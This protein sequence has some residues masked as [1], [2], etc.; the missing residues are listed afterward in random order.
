MALNNMES[1]YVII[2]AHKIKQC[3]VH[4]DFC[5]IGE[6]NSDCHSCIASTGIESNGIRQPATG[7][8]VKAVVQLCYNWI[9]QCNRPQM[10]SSF[11]LWDYAQWTVTTANNKC[12]VLFCED[13]HLHVHI[14]TVSTQVMTTCA[15]L[16]ISISIYLP[17]TFVNILPPPWYPDEKQ[18]N[19]R[20]R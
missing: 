8:I 3:H 17:S 20:P 19:E 4:Y 13:Y 1:R 12:T 6:W 9:V 18:D 5:W 15:T 7:W 10:N 11:I 14:I 2:F 16:E